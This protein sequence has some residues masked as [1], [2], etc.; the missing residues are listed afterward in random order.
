MDKT[1][2]SYDKRV[3][4]G[5]QKENKMLTLEFKAYAKPDQFQAIDEAIRI[6]QFI[7]N[8][9]IRLWIDGMVELNHGSLFLSI[10]RF[11]L[12]N[13]TNANKLGAMA[14][15]ASAERA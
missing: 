11:G 6:C 5:V 1:N 14:R 15:Q 8:K 3:L 10:V 7:R 4:T 9:S 13:L 2:H 12:K